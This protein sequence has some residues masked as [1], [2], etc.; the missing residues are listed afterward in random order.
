MGKS[1]AR[2]S[3]FARG[4]IVGK[5]EEGAELKKIRKTVPKKDGK[6]GS[7]RA[8]KA[9]L[10]RAREDPNWQGED[11]SAG[12]RPQELDGGELRKLRKLIHDE[13]GLAKL[14]IPYL[15]KRLPFLRRLSKE[16]IRQTLKR[17]GFAWRLRRGK[18]A[19]AKKYKPERLVWSDW[20]EKQPQS[21]LNHYAYV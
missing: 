6:R 8:I 20:V 9:V 16:C 10:R 18:A 4:R 5:F 15:K 14:N 12:G 3:T 19:I 13:V 2:F 21:D 7:L 1:T 11:S 17:L